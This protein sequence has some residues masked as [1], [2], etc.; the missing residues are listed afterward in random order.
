MSFIQFSQ[1]FKSGFK[2]FWMHILLTILSGLFLSGIYWIGNS[3]RDGFREASQ[4]HSEMRRAINY[5]PK[6]S[7]EHIEFEM[8][9]S[10]YDIKFAK[11]SRILKIDL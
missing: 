5:M 2:K 10:A 7:A 8:R 4:F 1:E 3:V 11:L 6:D 9:D